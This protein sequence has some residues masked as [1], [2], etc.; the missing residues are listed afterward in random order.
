MKSRSESHR[1]RQLSPTRALVVEDDEVDVARREVMADGEAGL[2]A[3]DDDGL[4]SL[5]AG[6]GAGSVQ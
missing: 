5:D 2:P 1:R 4:E 6:G 3:A